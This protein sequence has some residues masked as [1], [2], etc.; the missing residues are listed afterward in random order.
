MFNFIRCESPQDSLKEPNSYGFD[1]ESWFNRFEKVPPTNEQ[2]MHKSLVEAGLGELWA[3]P[4]PAPPAPEPHH[5]YEEGKGWE[6]L[7]KTHFGLSES[8]QPDKLTSEEAR[9]KTMK[10]AGAVHQ[11]EPNDA[12]KFL[13][14]EEFRCLTQNSEHSS[15]CLKYFEEWKQ[16]A[17]DQYKFNEG[18]TYIERAPVK[19][20][21]RFAPN[22]K[23]E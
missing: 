19:K 8:N 9:V 17:W 7:V 11:A 2:L 10:F 18:L 13:A 6:K 16:C 23:Y 1:K 3:G 15:K 5:P 14:I 21:Y 20:S 12:C 4:Q 22:Y